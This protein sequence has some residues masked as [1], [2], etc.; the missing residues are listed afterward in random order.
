MEPLGLEALAVI[1]R[2][3]ELTDF[4]ILQRLVRLQIITKSMTGEEIARQISSILSIQYGVST[5]HLLAAIHDRAS[6]NNVAIRSIRIL[7]PSS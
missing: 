2:Y 5:S 3:V 4:C 1:V 6:A 7:Y